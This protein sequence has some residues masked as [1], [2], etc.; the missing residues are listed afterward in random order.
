MNIGKTGFF[1]STESCLKCDSPRIFSPIKIRQSKYPHIYS[2]KIM[3]SS[4]FISTITLTFTVII[5]YSPLWGLASEARRGSIPTL[6]YNIKTIMY[7]MSSVILSVIFS[8]FY[9]NFVIFSDFSRKSWY[10]YCRV[11]HFRSNKNFGF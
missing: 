4:K 11:R 8:L 2:K 1:N 3:I 9:L 7:N 6:P 10:R 5:T